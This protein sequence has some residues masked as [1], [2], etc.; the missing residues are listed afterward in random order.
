MLLACSQGHSCRAE[1]TG[2]VLRPFVPGQGPGTDQLQPQHS[3]LAGLW[4]VTHL[5]LSGPS[6]GQ[7]WAQVGQREMPW[8]RL[9]TTN[10]NHCGPA[11]PGRGSR[12]QLRVLWQQAHPVLLSQRALRWGAQQARLALHLAAHGAAGRVEGRL[13]SLRRRSE[14]REDGR[15]GRATMT[16]SLS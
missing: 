13:P 3:L 11:R 10:P 1:D 9:P 14:V 15:R 7:P 2:S 4:V 6:G 8:T 12:R 16:T 5:H